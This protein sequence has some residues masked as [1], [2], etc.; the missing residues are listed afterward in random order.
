M[1]IFPSRLIPRPVNSGRIFFGIQA[2]T[3]I[4]RKD[5]GN[6]VLSKKRRKMHYGPLYRV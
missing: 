6:G 5:S 4:N 1:T 2:V 3:V